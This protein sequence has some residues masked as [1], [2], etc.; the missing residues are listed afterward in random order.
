MDDFSVYGDSYEH[1]LVNLAKV[2]QR[3]EEKQL[4]LN[5][6]KCHFMVTMGIVLGHIISGKGIEVEPAKVDLIQKLS[7][8]R[9]V[10]DVRS[11]LGHADFYR[12][13]IKSFSQIA[14]PLCELLGH[15]HQFEWTN[16]CQLAFDSLKCHLTTAP[17]IRPP[18]W[19]LPFKLMCDA[20][21]FAIGGVLG[22]RKDKVPYVIHYAS[23]TLNN[24]QLNY[25]T[26]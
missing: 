19:A 25:T 8:P 3:C 11:F 16:E 14:R 20:S 6:E 7:N 10:K 5:W 4:V 21:D 12:R 15:D 13:F 18:D 24:A 2:L 17:I 1:C 26:T 23:K 9:I 22:Q